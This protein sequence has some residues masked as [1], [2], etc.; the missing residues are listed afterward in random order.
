MRITLTVVD[1]P[2]KGQ[3]FTFSGH[4]TFLVGRSRRAHFQ[5]PAKDKYFSRIHFL[6]EVNPPRCRIMDMGSR[7]GTHVNGQKIDTTDLNDGDQ[8]RAGHTILRVS[9]E[10]G[11]PEVRPEVSIPPSLPVPAP[12]SSPAVSPPSVVPVPFCPACDNPLVL[13]APLCSACQGF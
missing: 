5:L 9:F 3:V 10:S 8:I 7:N 6:V 13:P 4:D 1:G 2:H 12:K 11:E